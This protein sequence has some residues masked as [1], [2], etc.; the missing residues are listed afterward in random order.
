[1]DSFKAPGADVFESAALISETNVFSGLGIMATVV[2]VVALSLVALAGSF[3]SA[4]SVMKVLLE[5]I[6][7]GLP[8]RLI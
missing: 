7:N 6:D 1:M 3:Q 4:N 5:K 8:R 2:W